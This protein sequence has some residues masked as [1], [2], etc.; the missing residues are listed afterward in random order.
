M[1]L[2]LA[3]EG[4][5][6]YGCHSSCPLPAIVEDEGIDSRDKGEPLIETDDYEN[7]CA[8]SKTDRDRLQAPP[9]SLAAV[10]LLTVSTFV[11]QRLQER[12][13]GCDLDF[14]LFSVVCER[15]F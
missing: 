4:E 2:R 7:G 8:L 15:R 3:N 9:M 5:G 12:A 13:V 11:H 14:G 10:F 6:L 1:W